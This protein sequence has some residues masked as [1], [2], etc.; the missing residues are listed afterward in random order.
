MNSGL[1]AA[2]NHKKSYAAK[3]ITRTTA[4]QIM[5]VT[6]GRGSKY[7]EPIGSSANPLFQK[8]HE[9]GCRVAAVNET[10]GSAIAY[11][12]THAASDLEHLTVLIVLRFMTGVVLP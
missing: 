1:G 10:A 9:N 8:Q 7:R 5:S 2:D 12:A 4:P 3:N 11:A 6:V